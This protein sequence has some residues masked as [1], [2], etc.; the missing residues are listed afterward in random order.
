MQSP[1]ATVSRLLGPLIH[2]HL[3]K[4][5]FL[6]EQERRLGLLWSA[7]TAL[8]KYAVQIQGETQPL[9]DSRSRRERVGTV[10]KE[11]IFEAL[12]RRKPTVTR[13]LKLFCDRRVD[14]LKHHAPD[15]LDRPE[16]KVI[17]YEEFRKL[18]LDDPF[19]NDSYLCLSK[20]P[21]AVDPTVRTGIHAVL[22]LKRANEELVQLANE[23]RRCVSWGLHYHNQLKFRIDQCVFGGLMTLIFPPYRGTLTQCFPFTQI[24]P[25]GI[26]TPLWN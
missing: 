9:R 13:A 21:W 5:H 3:I 8:Y 14:Y 12:D 24:L 23:L 25:M 15:Q 20:D 16:N 22:R 10:L 18:Q 19:W 11:K 1:N 26:S 4:F 6:G 7:K 2:T 17:D